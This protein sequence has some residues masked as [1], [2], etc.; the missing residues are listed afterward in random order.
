MGII[1]GILGAAA[2]LAVGGLIVSKTH[3]KSPE[4][5]LQKAGKRYGPCTLL[6][7][8]ERD[9]KVFVTVR[10]NLQGFTYTL[11]SAM[12]DMSCDGSTLFH[13]ENTTDD[14][15][16]RLFEFTLDRIRPQLEAI[17]SFYGASSDLQYSPDLLMEIQTS[18]ANTAADVTI[19]CFNVWQGQNAYHRLDRKTISVHTGE[20]EHLGSMVLPEP[21]FLNR[22]AEKVRCVMQHIISKAG[23]KEVRYLRTETHTLAEI[24]CVPERVSPVAGSY[25]PQAPNDPVR[26]YYFLV[27]GKEYFAA[28]FFDNQTGDLFMNYIV[29]A[30]RGFPRL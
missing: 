17:L 1:Q 7:T 5:I 14:F 29:S 6:S 20:R 25:Y 2:M 16:R 9:G 23:G 19:R 22:D 8:E 3:T 13:Y 21:A 10:D 30:R 15:D 11:C 24:G 27:G 12:Q 28:D 18:D 4:K 26:C